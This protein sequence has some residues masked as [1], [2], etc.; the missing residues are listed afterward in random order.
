MKNSIIFALVLA[1]VGVFSQVAFAS[2]K[3]SAAPVATLNLSGTIL[4]A[5]TSETLAGVSIKVEGSEREVKTDLDGKFSISGLTPGKYNL[6]VSYISYKESS[7]DYTVS[8]NEKNELKL[9]L[10]AE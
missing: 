2:G 1:F 5:E 4:D 3:E 8:I 6:K 10:K 7:V 9:S